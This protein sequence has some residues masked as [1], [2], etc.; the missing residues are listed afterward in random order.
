MYKR[1]IP[2]IFAAAVLVGLASGQDSGNERSADRTL[3]GSGRVNA[4]TLGMEFDLP[5]GSYPGRGISVP[6]NLSYSS[7]SW[8]MDYTGDNPI[9]GSQ[10]GECFPHYAAMFSEK[11]ASGWTTSLA[12]PYIEYVGMTGHYDTDGK[13]ISNYN[14]TCPTTGGGGSFPFYYIRRILVHLPGGETHELRPDDIAIQ[15]PP[16]GTS[17]TSPY[18]FSNWTGTYFSGDGSNL[19]YIQNP[20]SGTYR[21]QMPDGS[22]YDFD[23]TAAGRATKF[24]DRNGNFT[25]YHGPGSVD[26]N[27]VTHPNGYWRDTL[28]RNISIPIGLQAPAV[29]TTASNPQVYS[30]PGMTGTYKLQWKNLK[31][32]SASE[33]ALTN[34]SEDLKYPGDT[35]ACEN[36]SGFPTYCT[37]QPGTFLFYGMNLS[38]VM[39]N[40]LF[41]PILLTE[42]ELPT[43]QKYKFSYDVYGR[44]E[45]IVYPT[46]GEEV[47]QYAE[48]DSLSTLDPT[49]GTAGQTNFG[50]VNR[51]V[52]PTAAGG[53]FYGW[54]YSGVR[55]AS[56]YTVA[57]EN[58]DGTRL[59]RYLHPGNPFSDNPTPFGYDNILAGMAFEERVYDNTSPGKIVSK[60]LSTWTKTVAAYDPYTLSQSGQW[61]P[62]ATAEESIIYD[63][64]ANGI[65]ATATFEYEGD[66]SQKETPLLLKKSSQYAFVSAGSPLPSS[67]VKISESTFL[68]NDPDLPQSTRDIYKNQNMTGL[69]TATQIKDSAGTAVSRSEM[70]YDESGYSPNAGRGN[71]TTARV[72][73]STKGTISNPSAYIE[74]HA[75][76]DQWGNQYEVIDARGNS[77]TTTYDSTHHAFPIQV[78]SPIPD[79]SGLNGSSTAFVTTA[80]FNYTTGLPLTTTDANGLE[81][82]IEYD[83]VSLRPLNTKTYHGGIQVGSTSETIYHDE[84]NNYWVKNRSQIDAS[85][86]AESIT[87]FDGLGRAWKSEDV[88]SEGNIFVEKEFDSDGRVLRVTNPYRQNETKHWT[89][90]VY[91]EASRIK[92]VTLQDGAR[93]L[94]DYGVSSAAPIGV[95]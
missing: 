49:D 68:I 22:Y 80:T 59:E 29:P 60:K 84:P 4:S 86:W 34:F 91:D 52:Y 36:P 21:L 24:T 67:P 82:R 11:S 39:G 53:G 38:R 30:M 37:R 95:T 27:G 46:G 63:A 94:T 64:A 72:W 8:R 74:T 9:P 89:T 23:G 85:S 35:Y 12:V 25:T 88:N 66:L 3:R 31:G 47:F 33:S 13:P 73:D 10:S 48:M 70:V 14:V 62:R 57:T 51:K 7:K 90:N 78:T 58:P 54:E 93:V 41:N 50:V 28:G 44:I 71:P 92:E 16:S 75:K 83:P 19:K 77:T 45:K 32:G 65:S 56:S 5:L 81:T 18:N 87:Y 40:S 43:G 79:P 69:V 42:V 1:L 76:F 55:D 26:S 2:S 61:H 20:A 15:S 6:I 17:G